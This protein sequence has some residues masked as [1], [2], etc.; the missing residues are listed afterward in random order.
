MHNV[1]PNRIAELLDQRGLKLIDI[2]ALC[3]VDQSTASRWRDG[4]IPRQH[5]AKIA[6]F[7]GVSV[8]Y[9]DGWI[10]REPVA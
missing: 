4:I 3:R 2:A 7:L 10:D 1:P 8:P 9:L 5:V 6:E